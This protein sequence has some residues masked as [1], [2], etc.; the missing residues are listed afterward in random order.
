MSDAVTRLNA[1]LEGRY[2]IEHELGEGGMATVYLADDIKHERKG[3]GDK[4]GLIMAKRLAPERPK[5]SFRVATEWEKHGIGGHTPFLAL[6]RT[7]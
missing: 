7:P 4:L 6:A 5:A 3:V 1:V 2:A